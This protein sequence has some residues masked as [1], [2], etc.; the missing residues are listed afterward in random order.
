MQNLQQT[1]EA[2]SC[3][4]INQESQRHW[5]E[6]V[7]RCR[8]SGVLGRYLRVNGQY[9]GV[10]RRYDEFREILWKS[11]SFKVE[12]NGQIQHTQ[13]DMLVHN[14]EVF[15]FH[16]GHGQ[17]SELLGVVFWDILSFCLW[18]SEFLDSTV[19]YGILFRKNEG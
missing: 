13:C 18:S 15:N 9:F 3:P 12:L 8:R 1:N 16:Y 6:K 19:H 5:Q 2:W 7:E 17:C 14:G 11:N 4:I 10:S